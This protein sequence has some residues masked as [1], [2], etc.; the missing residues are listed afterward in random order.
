MPKKYP[1][2][3]HRWMPAHLMST[4]GWVK[5]CRARGCPTPMKAVRNPKLVVNNG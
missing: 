1:R 4:V 3:K 2:H 5:A